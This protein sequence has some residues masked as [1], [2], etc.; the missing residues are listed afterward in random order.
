MSTLH[1]TLDPK[2]TSIAKAIQTAA[3]VA[4][5][6]ILTARMFRE[7]AHELGSDDAAMR[8][9]LTVSERINKPIG[10]NFPIAGGSRTAFIAPISWTQARLRGWVGARHEEISTMFGPAVAGPLQDV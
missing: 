2:A 10:C 1:V 7:L 4:P 3:G 6:V 9:L 5:L 8:H